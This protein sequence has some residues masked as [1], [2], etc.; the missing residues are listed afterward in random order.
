[1]KNN[2]ISRIFEH[3]TYRFGSTVK[4]IFKVGAAVLISAS[5]MMSSISGLAVNSND[6][7]SQGAQTTQSSD[8]SDSSNNSDNSQKTAQGFFLKR[9]AQS[10]CIRQA[11]QK[12]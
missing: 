7:D 2:K 9:T 4:S 1:M 3:E 5:M 12:L 11:Q 6:A 8:N 10:E